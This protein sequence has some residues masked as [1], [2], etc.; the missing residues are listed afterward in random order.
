MITF[1]QKLLAVG[2]VAGLN[3]LF[4]SLSFALGSG[5]LLL[6]AGLFAFSSIAFAL[7]VLAV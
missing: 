1:G 4:L 6:I 5:F 3:L 7:R 2:V